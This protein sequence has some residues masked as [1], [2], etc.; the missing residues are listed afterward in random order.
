MPKEYG[1]PGPRAIYPDLCTS[2]SVASCS[3]PAQLLFERLIAQADDQG[4]LEGDALV[5]KSLCVPLV[6]KVPA[7]PLGRGARRIAGIDDLLCELEAED[8]VHRYENGR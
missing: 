3:L 2:R 6:D 8:L 4:R 7:R 1:T 5:L